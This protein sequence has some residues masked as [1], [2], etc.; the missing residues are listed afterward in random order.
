MIKTVKKVIVLTAMI[1]LGATLVFAQQSN[2]DIATFGQFKTDVDR[3]LHVNNWSEIDFNGFFGYTRF[4]ANIP[5]GVIDAGVA[6]KAGNLYLAL[7]YNGKVIGLQDG[8]SDSY[9][10]N[11]AKEA[12]TESIN[13]SAKNKVNPKATYGALVG[14]NN[15][16]FKFT[17]EDNLEVDGTPINSTSTENKE[18]WTGNITPTLAVGLP[19][20]LYRIILGVPIVYGREEKASIVPPQASEG[21]SATFSTT[22]AGTT[23]NDPSSLLDAEGN[24]G[25]ALI[26]VLQSCTLT[27]TSSLIFLAFPTG[28]LTA[29][30]ASRWAWPIQKLSS[31]LSRTIMV[32]TIAN[33]KPITTTV[34]GL[35]KQ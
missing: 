2:T 8:M 19:G 20:K 26:L 10:V 13:L 28:V 22:T 17:F 16:G 6:A 27:T 5:A 1:V 18:T 25:A 12:K 23:F 15:L 21:D 34:S 11:L 30:K 31:I 7:Y 29:K 9:K 32:R 3:F 4:G 24:Y 14:V 33:M 35:R